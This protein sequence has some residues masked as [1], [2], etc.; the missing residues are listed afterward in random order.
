M[1]L[2][3]VFD[4]IRKE[5]WYQPEEGLFAEMVVT[6]ARNNLIEE[7]ERVY[8]LAKSE[9]LKPITWLSTEVIRAQIG[10]RNIT[11]SLEVYNELKE[12]GFFP[13]DTAYGVLREGLEKNGEVELASS[14]EQEYKK[15]IEK[16][17]L[18]S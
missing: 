17:A 4:I 9:N 10:V 6:L 16:V 12:G 5:Y 11:K 7:V 8:C 14:I 18:S 15:A 1:C 2:C 13:C 3:Q